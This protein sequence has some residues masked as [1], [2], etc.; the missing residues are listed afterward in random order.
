MR[1]FRIILFF[2]VMTFIKDDLYQRLKFKKSL[3]QRNHK[4][5]YSNRFST[6]ARETASARNPTAPVAA[7][8][9]RPVLLLMSQFKLIQISVLFRHHPLLATCSVPLFSSVIQSAVVRYIFIVRHYDWR[10]LEKATLTTA[11]SV[12]WRNCPFSS[13]DVAILESRVEISSDR[14]EQR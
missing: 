13:I 8:L 6:F 12:W 5:G 3:R 10:Q 4:K 11:T 14:I 2:P 9:L 1:S 7:Q